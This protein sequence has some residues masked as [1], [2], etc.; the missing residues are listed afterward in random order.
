[1]ITIIR[2]VALLNLDFAQFATNGK[3]VIIWSVVEWGVA[4][5]VASAPILRPLFDRLI[6]NKPLTTYGSKASGRWTDPTNKGYSS[7]YAMSSNAN[8]D[9]PDRRRGDVDLEGS[10]RS[11]LH[12]FD[13]PYTTKGPQ[14]LH[15]N[16][17]NGLAS[18]G[19]SHTWAMERP[20]RAARPSAR[21]NNDIHVQTELRVH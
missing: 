19:G 15:T 21:K 13:E 6:R 8:H 3:L 12:S 4:L 9:E 14:Q 1:V 18:P 16:A 2:V 10:T 5:V 17:G 11:I 20:E 7:V